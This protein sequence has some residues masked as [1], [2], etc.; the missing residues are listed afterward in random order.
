[1]VRWQL[2]GNEEEQYCLADMISNVKVSNEK[3]QWQHKNYGIDVL[4]D[5]N[6]IME[7]KASYYIYNISIQEYD[8]N[9]Q[10]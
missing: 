1:M 8:R 6:S 3:Q 10:K 2:K 7:F 5:S 9:V 4:K